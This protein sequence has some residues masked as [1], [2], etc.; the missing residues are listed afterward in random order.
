M[1]DLPTLDEL[2]ETRRRLAEEQQCDVNRYAQMLRKRSQTA[3]HVYITEPLFPRQ[4]L[5]ESAETKA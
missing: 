5:V 1:I 3:A 4:P 2:R